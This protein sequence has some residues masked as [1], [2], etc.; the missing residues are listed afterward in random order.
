MS[1]GSRSAK[2]RAEEIE[3]QGLLSVKEV[4]VDAFIRLRP[5]SLREPPLALARPP[6][7]G[8]P[9]E[10]T[11]MRGWLWGGGVRSSPLPD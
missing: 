9:L 11:R 7:A 5:D 10:G 2:L 3:E 8:K 6:E 1:E 4:G